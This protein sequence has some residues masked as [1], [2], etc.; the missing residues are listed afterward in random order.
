M[1]NNIIDNNMKNK[2]VQGLT[3]KS[4]LSLEPISDNF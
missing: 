1:N 2:N 4:G 3:D